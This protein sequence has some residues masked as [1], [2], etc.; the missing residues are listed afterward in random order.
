M[1]LRLQKNLVIS[2]LFGI[3]SILFIYNYVSKLERGVAEQYKNEAVLIAVMDIPAYQE[4]TPDKVAIKEIPRNLVLYEA[5]KDIKS[6]DG[7]VTSVDI[8]AGEQITSRRLIEKN[9]ADA[10]MVI[11]SG[12]RAVTISPDDTGN[13]GNLVNARDRVDVI[14]ANQTSSSDGMDVSV[15]EDIEIGKIHKKR[16]DA[17]EDNALPPELSEESLIDYITLIVTQKQA[18]EIM[19]ADEYGKVRI[20][21]RP[22]EPSGVKSSGSS[23]T[24]GIQKAIEQNG[25]VTID[26]LKQ[27]PVKTP[28]PHIVAKSKKIET[29]SNKNIRDQKDNPTSH[30]IGRT[31]TIEVIRGMESVAVTVSD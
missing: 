2:V 3:L 23:N 11:P 26:S 20:A 12:M 28:Q 14:L 15:L 16:S 21:L 8:I 25:Y 22:K 13:L 1:N 10:P 6:A 30:N 5:I 4:L 27:K 18:E 24:L 29:N 31:K 17:G 9:K 19:Y 7:K